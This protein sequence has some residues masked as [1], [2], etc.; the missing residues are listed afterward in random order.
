MWTAATEKIDLRTAAAV[1]YRNA[2]DFVYVYSKYT[3][4]TTCAPN[5]SV[6]S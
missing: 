3:L 4:H 2:V 5:L 6:Y 1:T